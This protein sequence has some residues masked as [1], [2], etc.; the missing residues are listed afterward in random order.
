MKTLHSKIFTLMEKEL[1]KVIG[2]PREKAV[3]RLGVPDSWL[4][5]TNDG[6]TALNIPGLAV[7]I[8]DKDAV[9]SP[10]ETQS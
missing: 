2:M 4:I 5:V 9:E 8:A 7:T 1:T 3:K 10:V 6:K